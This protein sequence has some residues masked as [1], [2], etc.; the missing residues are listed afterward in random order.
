MATF[1]LTHAENKLEEELE[2]LDGMLVGAERGASTP[3][4]QFW[5]VTYAAARAGRGFPYVSSG[6]Q[7]IPTNIVQHYVLILPPFAG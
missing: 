4:E 5:A 7:T 2:G 6:I 3:S 1:D